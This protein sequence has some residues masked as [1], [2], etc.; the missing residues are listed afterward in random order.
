M[1][2]VMVNPSR[3]NPGRREKIQ[4]NFYFH[5]SLWCLKRFFEGLCGASKG[6][7]KALKAFIKSFEAPQRS[8]KI[9]ILLNFHFN[10]TFR[11]ARDGEG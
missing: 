8:A 3:P 9:N 2:N 6:F 10:R 11:N 7:I 5:I 4:L 1:N